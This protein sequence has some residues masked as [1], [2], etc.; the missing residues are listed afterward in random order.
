ME[1]G[2]CPRTYKGHINDK[3]FVGLSINDG[4]IICDKELIFV[5]K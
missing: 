5:Y 1:T 2:T 3:N 4:Y